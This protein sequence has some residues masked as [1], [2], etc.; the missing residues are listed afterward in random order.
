MSARRARG[1]TLIE[2]I[3]FIV[4]VGAGLAG[5]L[6]VFSN[7][8]MGSADPVEP[9]QALMVA[10]AKMEEVLL[11]EFAALTAVAS[12]P[13]TDITGSPLG[14]SGYTVRIDVPAVGVAPRNVPIASQ[15]AGTIA[16]PEADWKQIVVTVTVSGRDYALTGYRF[17]HE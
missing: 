2:L 13:V 8:V 16:V 14:L 15:G 12:G 17:N 1:F 4:V 5:I 6:A 10:E 9:K 7:V 11:Q 3:I